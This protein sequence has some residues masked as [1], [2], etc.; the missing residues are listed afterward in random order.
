MKLNITGEDTWKD[1]YTNDPTAC[2]NLTP[3]EEAM[4]WGGEAAYVYTIS[5]LL[6]ISIWC[7]YL[8]GV[9]RRSSVRILFVFIINKIISYYYDLFGLY[10]YLLYY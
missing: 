2:Y 9:G 8:I 3:A 5:Y 10:C 1:F 7:Y 4:V 6:I